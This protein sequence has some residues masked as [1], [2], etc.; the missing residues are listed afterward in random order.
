MEAPGTALETA[1]MVA[2]GQD[3]SVGQGASA[4]RDSTV[5]AEREQAEK[6]KNH[7]DCA[8]ESRG[9]Y[10]NTGRAGTGGERLEAAYEKMV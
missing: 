2:V 6:Q 9:R 5:A 4:G 3:G 8:A 1:G 10:F 7:P